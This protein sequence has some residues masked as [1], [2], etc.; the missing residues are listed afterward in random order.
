[1]RLK[2]GHVLKG[3]L[4]CYEVIEPLEPSGD[5]R[6]FA[7][8]AHVSLTEPTAGPAAPPDGATT[9]PQYVFIK[10]PRIQDNA[11]YPVI[12]EKLAEITARFMSQYTQHQSL[13]DLRNEIAYVFDWGWTPVA[14]GSLYCVP[15][16]A[17]RFVNGVTLRAYLERGGAFHGLAKARDW[18]KHAKEI[19]DLVKRLHNRGL[20]HGDISPD[21]IMIEEDGDRAGKPTVV[22]FGEA[23]LYSQEM[24]GRGVKVDATQRRHRYQAPERRTPGES[25]YHPA[26]IYSLGAVFYFMATGEDPS[27]N[28]PEDI[29][30]L[31]HSVYNAIKRRNEALFD[32]SSG[33]GIA[34][35]IDKCLRQ[36][37]YERYAYVESLARHLVLFSREDHELDVASLDTAVERLQETKELVSSQAFDANNNPFFLRL[38]LVEI[39]RARRRLETMTR[40]HVEIVGERE[41]LI[42]SLLEYLG[43]LGPGDEYLTITSPQLWTDD[44]LGI[45]GR[46]LTMNKILAQE[47]VIIRR[48]FTLCEEDRE[49]DVVVRILQSHL[50]MMSELPRHIARD[51]GDGSGLRFYTGFVEI[52]PDDRPSLLSLDRP[53]AVWRRRG[54]DRDV[55][56]SFALRPAT[57]SSRGRQL[58][59]P[60][61][62]DSQAR[63]SIGDHV[64]GKVRFWSAKPGESEFASFRS[65][66]GRSRPLEQFVT[67]AAP[68][69]ARKRS[70]RSKS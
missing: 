30:E 5:S 35:V 61:R 15:F 31:K 22:D 62:A 21:N 7:Y 18:F 16:L 57:I 28:Q 56:I 68:R 67:P 2:I 44:N 45:N 59:L 66:I 23:V 19:S 9:P 36:Q 58:D 47:G 46:F 52:S 14:E 63:T 40:G 48:V 69:P 43:A 17:Q 37:D 64:I 27:L 1:M 49:N 24:S 53:V 12:Q 3:G 10:T 65:R 50:D 11:P 29:H 33:A 34:K 8:K 6:G 13:G 26:D 39:D 32:D 20:V 51:N 60:E 38:A 41:E 42:D 4:W 54:A 70:R 25:W 55:S